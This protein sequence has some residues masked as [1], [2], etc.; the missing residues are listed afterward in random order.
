[1]SK[2]GTAFG[3]LAL[4][5]LL[6]G[7][8]SS[9]GSSSASSQTK[10]PRVVAMVNV[11]SDSYSYKPKTI[12]VA[13]GTRVTFVNQSSAPH[14]VTPTG[15]ARAFTEADAKQIDPKKSWAFTFSKPGTY[16]Y[17]CIFHPYMLGKVIVTR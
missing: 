10:V 8:G 4:V 5:L 3:A 2:R 7:C 13:A 11:G 9:G 1:M 12:K 16:A 6:A 17:Y 15:A 14:S